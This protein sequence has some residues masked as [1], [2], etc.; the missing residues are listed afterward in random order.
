MVKKWISIFLF[1]VLSI[2]LMPLTQISAALYQGQLTEEASHT[3][4]PN[5][6]SFTEEYHKQFEH[7]TTIWHLERCERIVS[8]VIHHAEGIYSRIHDE[9]EI[10][11]PDFLILV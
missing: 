8:E 9:V 11:P 3:D 6:T 4:N 2:Q 10:Q 7:C 1:L 5:P